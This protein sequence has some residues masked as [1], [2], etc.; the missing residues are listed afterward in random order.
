LE[1]AEVTWRSLDGESEISGT[2]ITLPSEIDTLAYDAG[3]DMLLIKHGRS[4]YLAYDL[5]RSAVMWAAEGN[6]TGIHQLSHG[7]AVLRFTETAGNP[8]KIFDSASGAYLRLSFS[9][10][11]FIDGRDEVLALDGNAFIG[12][13]YSRVDVKS[14]EKEW[15]RPVC[16]YSRGAV[17]H[18]DWF[19][20]I[21]VDCL[22][23]FKLTDG[24]GWRLPL[25]TSSGGTHCFSYPLF[26][27]DR[28]YIVARNRILCVASETG[29][30]IWDRHTPVKSGLVTLLTFGEAIVLAQP[31][32]TTKE[33]HVKSS[34]P[35]QVL[36]YAAA[37][38]ESLACFAPDCSEGEI[39][40]DFGT[41]DDE[42]YLLMTEHIQKLN[43]DLE[44]VAELDHTEETG[45]FLRFVP[46]EAELIARTEKGLL[47]I[48]Q[49]AV[50]PTW[51]EFVEDVERQQP[52]GRRDN[53][54]RQRFTV[55][56][57]ELWSKHE[58]GG[59]S[60]LWSSNGLWA[61][62]GESGRRHVFPLE[63]SWEL[64]MFGGE[65]LIAVAGAQVLV[66]DL[67]VQRVR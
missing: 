61:V 35:P 5:A 32:W 19:Y 15:E 67:E 16:D 64:E 58:S 54:L 51:F 4:Q 11:K 37:D 9:F 55:V 63:S 43:S 27:G 12:F 45:W 42:F 48:D 7:V 66:L 38:G 52:E 65:A 46:S 18:G 44:L 57:R 30:V 50:K 47:G 3:S 21:G 29:D 39:V 40:T 6:P 62:D 24:S 14:G 33:I 23:A 25:S 28:A 26:V 10:F 59:A 41:L 2:V 20:S 1:E 49:T 17:V 34:A 56:Q 13:T 36:T 53:M 22:D 31:G 60:W 8:R